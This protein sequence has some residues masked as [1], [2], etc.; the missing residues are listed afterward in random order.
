MQWFYLLLFCLGVFLW[1]FFLIKHTTNTEHHQV[2]QADSTTAKKK[3]M[4]L[5]ILPYIAKYLLQFCLPSSGKIRR[6][7]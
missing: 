1:L 5:A 6:D 7:S 4:Q 2:S 3:K